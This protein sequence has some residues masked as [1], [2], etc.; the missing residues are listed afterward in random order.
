M[1]SAKFADYTAR[2]RLFGGNRMKLGVM[3]QLQPWLDHYHG[4]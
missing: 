3:L 4:A 2:N 1:N